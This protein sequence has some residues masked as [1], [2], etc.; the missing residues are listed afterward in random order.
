[1][2]DG[3]AL[4]ET[5]P[6]PLI[7]GV[8]FVGFIGAYV[9]QV[10]GPGQ[11]LLAR[12]VAAALVTWFTFLSSF[13]F[14]LAGGPLVEAT[15]HEIRFTAPLISITAAVVGVILKLALFFG[16]YVLWPNGF[17]STFD[18]PSAVIAIAAAITL[19][20]L[21]RSVIQVLMACAIPGVAVHLLR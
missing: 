15:H 5:L 7:M 4:G 6:G 8:A 1:M 2:I 13:L 19:L 10:F 3:L 18:G 17:G 20:H 14:I 9:S 21:K 11:V 12:A 16:Y